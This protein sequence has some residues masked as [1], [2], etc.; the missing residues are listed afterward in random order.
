M[1]SEVAAI[2]VIIGGFTV[3]VLAW[4]GALWVREVRDRRALRRAEYALMVRAMRGVVA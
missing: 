2:L 3:Y 1:P 4:V